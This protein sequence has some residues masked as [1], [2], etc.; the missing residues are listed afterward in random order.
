MEI[1]YRAL[2]V[3]L[4]GTDDVDTLRGIANAASRKNPRNAGRKKRFTEEDVAQMEQ[5][6]NAGVSINR[7]AERF[8]TSRQVVGRYLT[9]KPKPGCTMRMTYM[10]RQ[11]PCTV[12]DVDFLKADGKE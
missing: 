7:I 8:G 3:E 6:R 5:L 2:C 4:F 9:E 1:D 11:H 12:I 10:F